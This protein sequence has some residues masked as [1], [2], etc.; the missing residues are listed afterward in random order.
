[1]SDCHC[2]QSASTQ[3]VKHLMLTSLCVQTICKREKAIN[4]CE[5]QHVHKITGINSLQPN[6]R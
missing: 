1:M 6:L 3:L 5:N 4:K 2:D